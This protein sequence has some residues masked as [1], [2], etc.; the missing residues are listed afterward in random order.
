AI[1]QAGD[2][3]GEVAF[4]VVSL[5]AFERSPVGLADTRADRIL[6]HAHFLETEQATT[7]RVLERLVVF[8]ERHIEQFGHFVVPGIATGRVLD[9]PHR[10]RHLAGLPVHRTRGPVALADLVEH[11]AADAYAGVG[12]EAGALTGIIV[13]RRLE[14][15]DHAGLNQVVHLYARRQPT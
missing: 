7:A 14:Q 8:V 9:R 15:P 13:A 3:L 6:V 10:L 2:G 11:R 4:E 1:R 5:N 12:L